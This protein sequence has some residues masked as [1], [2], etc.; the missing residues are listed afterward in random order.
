[1]NV[2]LTIFHVLLVNVVVQLSYST[3]KSMF[4][5]SVDTDDERY[6]LSNANYP[7]ISNK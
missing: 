7:N 1:M 4:N 5:N 2:K 3:T 6:E